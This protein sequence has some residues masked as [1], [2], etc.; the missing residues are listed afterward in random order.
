MEVSKVGDKLAHHASSQ[1]VFNSLS[2]SPI[3]SQI[4]LQQNP[5]KGYLNF[6]QFLIDKS[7]YPERSEKVTM[8]QMAADF[9]STP[10]KISKWLRQIYDDI[11]ELNYEKPTLFQTDGIKVAL[12]FKNYDSSLTFHTSLQTLPRVHESFYAYFVNAKVGTT[13]F[14]VDNVQHEF[15]NNNTQITIFLIGGF[16]NKYREFLLDRAVFEE[17]LSFYQAMTRYDFQIDQDLKKWYRS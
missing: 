6:L 5:D 1:D 16:V 12:H 4:L 17:Y 7:F 14:W 11:I 10:D 15:V 8:K 13:Y 9:K 2:G 3:Y